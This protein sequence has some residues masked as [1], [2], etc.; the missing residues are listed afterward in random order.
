MVSPL[1]FRQALGSWDERRE[2]FHWPG[3]GYPV[4]WDY[5][6]ESQQD[7]AQ[8]A[9]SGMV[10]AI[11]GS[12]DRRSETMGAGVVVGAG[13][14]PEVNISFPVGGPLSSL[15]AEAASL[16]GLLDA[17]ANDQPL[18]VFTDCLVL[19]VILHRWG[20]PDFGPTP[21][22]LSISTSLAPVSRNYG[23]DLDQLA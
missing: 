10:A 8:M 21:R 14:Q 6:R 1:E 22:T 18:L 11:D 4:A 15:R 2:D 17:V 5:Y 13:R 16:D 3:A 20:Q 19:L 12:V 23:D 9:W 7:F